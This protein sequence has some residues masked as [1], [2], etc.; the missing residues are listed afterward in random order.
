MDRVDETLLYSNYRELASAIVLQQCRDYIR[1]RK[2]IAKHDINKIE[3]ALNKALEKYEK[4]M[5]NNASEEE[6]QKAKTAYSTRKKQWTRYMTMADLVNAVE[7]DFDNSSINHW[8]TLLGIHASSE[9]LISALKAK[10]DKISTVID[11]FTY[12]K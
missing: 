6:I 9:T 1:A 3:A 12:K 10:G 8:L 2:Y 5:E 7:N 11:G 4:A